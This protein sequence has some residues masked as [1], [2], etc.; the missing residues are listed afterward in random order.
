[1]TLKDAHGALDSLLNGAP[2]FGEVS[3]KVIYH[4]GKITRLERA[5]VEKVVANDEVARQRG[6]GRGDGV[7]TRTI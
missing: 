7:C 4:E 2:E 6:S 1:M 3:L 5:V